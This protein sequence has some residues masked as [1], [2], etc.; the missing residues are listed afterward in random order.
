[1]SEEAT[2]DICP[3]YITSAVTDP[4]PV[5]FHIVFDHVEGPNP[6]EISVVPDAPIPEAFDPDCMLQ[7]MREA[8]TATDERFVGNKVPV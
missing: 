3:G 2:K 1:M 7:E 8:A 4:K 5:A 6:G